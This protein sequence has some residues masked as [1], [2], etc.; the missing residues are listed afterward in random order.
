MASNRLKINNSLS[1]G[2]YILDELAKP[3][4]GYCQAPTLFQ[5]TYL[6]GSPPPGQSWIGCKSP[7][8]QP[9]QPECVVCCNCPEGFN[10]LTS[11]PGP[12]WLCQSYSHLKKG[13]CCTR[14]CPKGYTFFANPPPGWWKCK[15]LSDG[16]GYCCLPVKPDFEDTAALPERI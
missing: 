2:V 1:V 6:C 13:Y 3:D 7:I 16:T 5:I 4:G 14:K 8:I 10:Y 12:A 9:S 15:S 11:Y